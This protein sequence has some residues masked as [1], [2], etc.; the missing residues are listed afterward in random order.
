MAIKITSLASNKLYENSLTRG[1][2]YKDLKFDLSK[3]MSFNNQL[4]RQE[5]LRDIDVLYD[6]ESVKNSI[7][8]AFTTVPGQKILNPTYG[9]NLTQYIFEPVDPFISM[10]I[11]DDIMTKLP[12]MEPRVSIS[13]VSVV[14]DPE[15][16][17][18]NIELQIDV[19]SLDITGVSLKSELTSNGYSIL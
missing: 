11:Q 2:L 12:D 17:S 15:N 4:N 10:I 6:L 7:V 9:I 18:Y 3:S 13:N 14:G 1:Y 8:N 5:T 19:P 16:Q